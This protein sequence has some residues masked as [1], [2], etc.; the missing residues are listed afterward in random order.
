MPLIRFAAALVGCLAAVALLQLHSHKHA[1]R[2]PV[3]TGEAAIP[4]WGPMDP[5]GKRHCPAPMVCP[6]SIIYF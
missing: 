6:K 4:V 3:Q 2:G 5:D 1:P